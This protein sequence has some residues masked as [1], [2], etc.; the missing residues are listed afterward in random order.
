MVKIRRS[1]T[2]IHCTRGSSPNHQ[3]FLRP[4]ATPS[5]S[6]GVNLRDRAATGSEMACFR[7][8]TSALLDFPHKGMAGSLTTDIPVQ[9]NR[10]YHFPSR[11]AAGERNRVL[12]RKQLADRIET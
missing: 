5:T 1:T 11:C 6:S 3:H 9:D 12:R 8:I 4:C 2:E 10:L 7:G